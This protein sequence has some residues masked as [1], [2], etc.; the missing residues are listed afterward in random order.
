MTG[1]SPA[2][3]PGRRS[4]GGPRRHPHPVSGS[5]GTKQSSRLQPS[6][7]PRRALAEGRKRG[8]PEE[9]GTEG[10][11]AEVT[12][13]GPGHVRGLGLEGHRQELGYQEAAQ[14]HK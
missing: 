6:G 5:A 3:Q 9:H 7:A 2:G 14:S 1:G 10:S 4:P 8:P 11:R 12:V 13:L